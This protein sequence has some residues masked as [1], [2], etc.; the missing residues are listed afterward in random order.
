MGKSFHTNLTH[1]NS[2]TAT[3]HAEVFLVNYD[4]NGNEVQQQQD[5]TM[6]PLLE[7]ENDQANLQV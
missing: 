5:A 7:I 3:L 2:L 6:Q 1:P 4:T